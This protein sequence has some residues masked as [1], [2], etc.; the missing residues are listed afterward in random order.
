[1]TRGIWVR[2][3][4]CRAK[5]IRGSALTEEYFQEC[6]WNFVIDIREDIHWN[7]YWKIEDIPRNIRN[8]FLKNNTFNHDSFALENKMMITKDIPSNIPRNIFRNIRYNFL[9]NNTFNHDSFALENK[10]MITKDILS[11][12][13]RNIPRNIRNNFLKNNTFNYDSFALENK[14]MIHTGKHS[15][16]SRQTFRMCSENIP[17]FQ[18]TIFWGISLKKKGYS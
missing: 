9:K 14:T 18:S 16:N 8:N 1:M 7:C 10:T 6:P 5:K 13:P 17:D 2:F 3:I 15:L 12:I 4:S 11:N